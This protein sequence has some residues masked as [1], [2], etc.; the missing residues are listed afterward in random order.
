[1]NTNRLITTFTL[2]LSLTAAI[3]CSK[4]DETP[5]GASAAKPAENQPARVDLAAINAAAPKELDLTFESRSIE[6]ELTAI[7]PVGWEAGRVFPG[8]LTPPS[9]SK[10]GFFTRFKVGSNCD[11]ACEPKEWA[12][13]VDKVEFERF[14]ADGAEVLTD[15]KA[16][17]H[18][19]VIGKADDRL[20]IV[21][22]W[23]KQDASRYFYCRAEL[24]DEALPAKAAFEQACRGMRVT[25]W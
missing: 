20:M 2:A 4:D 18:R 6:D 19:L 23:W 13:I 16:D 15:E 25:Q 9:G 5:G 17:G 21:A 3:G 12:P 10:L 14:S 8:N 24:D 11:G 7:V 1:M 22:A